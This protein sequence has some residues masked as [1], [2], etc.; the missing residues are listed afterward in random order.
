MKPGLS[1]GIQREL[2]FTVTEDMCP[3]FDGVVVHR[4]CATWTLVHYFEVAGRKMLIDFLADGEEGVG[5]H[6]SC[7][8][9]APAPI[10]ASVRV[11]ATCAA[12]TERELICDCVAYVGEKKIATGQ[13]GQRVFPKKVL[14]RLLG[15]G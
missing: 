9:L 2:S 1:V 14:K 4:V 6:A 11:V 8:H 5:S 10:G 12:V 3:A 13:T 7:D 15:E